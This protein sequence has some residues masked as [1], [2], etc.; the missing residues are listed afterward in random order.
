MGRAL[1][2]DGLVGGVIVHSVSIEIDYGAPILAMVW[3]RCD[4][5]CCILN[6]S[7]FSEV[8]DCD[9]SFLYQFVIHCLRNRYKGETCG[10]ISTLIDQWILDRL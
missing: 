10:V 3:R 5:T 8:L 4:A 7:N 6:A 2:A 9:V 1:L